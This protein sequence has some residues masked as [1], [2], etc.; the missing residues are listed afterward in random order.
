MGVFGSPHE[1]MLPLAKAIRCSARGTPRKKWPAPL[2]A[3]VQK[4]GQAKVRN[5]VRKRMGKAASKPK[6]PRPATQPPKRTT[7]PALNT[8]KTGALCSAQNFPVTES[9]AVVITWLD[10]VAESRGST[11]DGT[12]P[13]DE[14]AQSSPRTPTKANPSS[15]ARV[16]LAI[17]RFSLI[18]A[19]GRLVLFMEFPSRPNPSGTTPPGPSL[20]PR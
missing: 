15:S 13:S 16:R 2:K 14:I 7:K 9:P 12:F 8:T 1:R 3:S 17:A 19:R 6:A 5:A 20:F 10:A 11:P 18:V 4:Q